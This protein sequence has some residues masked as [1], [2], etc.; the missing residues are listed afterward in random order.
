M[1]T[2]ELLNKIPETVSIR[3]LKIKEALES[4]DTSLFLSS[5]RELF[6]QIPSVLYMDEEKYYHSL[7]I[8]IMY[9]SGIEIES[10]VNTNIGRIDG[11][12]ETKDKIYII[13]FK[14][15]KTPGEALQQ[16]FRKKYYEKYTGREKE[17]VLM[18]V[19]FTCGDIKMITESV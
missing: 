5:L 4:G 13:E 16:I 10:E 11:V 15:D 12:I 3:T 18:G 14:L 8:M 17:I 1:I 19:S 7:F 9:M 2:S 6:A